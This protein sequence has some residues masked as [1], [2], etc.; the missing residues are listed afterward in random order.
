M[1]YY[2]GESFENI[3]SLAGQVELDMP[4]VLMIMDTLRVGRSVRIPV[5]AN[6]LAGDSTSFWQD[7][8]HSND[9]GLHNV[10]VVE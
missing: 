6:L 9:T 4:A 5:L 2:G 1:T 8:S 3:E 7:S 10:E